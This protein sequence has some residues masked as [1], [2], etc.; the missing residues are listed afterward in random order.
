MSEAIRDV[1]GTEKLKDYLSALTPAARKMLI[2][3]IES[4]RA[5]G[6][7][8]PSLELILAA[9][10]DA[11]LNEDRDIPRLATAKRIFFTP[12]EPFLITE[13]LPTKQRGKLHRSSLDNIWNWIERDIAKDQFYELIDELN[14]AAN[15]GNPKEVDTVA[16][17]LRAKFL[18]VAREYIASLLS[19]P[20]GHRRFASHIGGQRVLD[21][22]RDLIDIF[23]CERSLTAMLKTLPDQLSGDRQSVEKT[24][25]ALTAFIKLEPRKG[26]FALSAMMAKFDPPEDFVRLAAIAAGS[27]D[28]AVVS[29]SPFAPAIELSLTEIAVFVERFSAETRKGKDVAT[30]QKYLRQYHRWMRAFTVAFEVSQTS[31]WGKRLSEFRST[32]SNRVSGLIDPAAALAKRALKPQRV[33]G[34]LLQADPEPLRDALVAIGLL[35]TATTCRDSLAINQLVREMRVSI[36]QIVETMTNG[37]LAELKSCSGS[38]CDI[39]ADYVQAGITLSALV[40]GDDYAAVIRRARQVALSQVAAR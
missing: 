29:K 34:T 13:T 14:L 23:E 26:V 15:G 19:S 4:A 33:D 2:T 5:R 27:D 24:T 20:E 32:M 37:C 3:G 17:K 28:L 12:V 40:F 6:Q 16:R 8:D 31:E 38:E 1:M 18:A 11:F 30:L 35:D 36:E 10:R 25:Q 22:L 39:L 21:D 9:A 7:S